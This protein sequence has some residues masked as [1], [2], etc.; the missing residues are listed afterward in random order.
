MTIL[1]L[2]FATL[3]EGDEVSAKLARQ[4]PR[5]IGAEIERATEAYGL[6]AKYLSARG[7]ALDGSPGLVAS[8]TMPS[9]TELLN[10]GEMY[11]AQVVVAGQL[12]LRDRDIHLEA[13]VFQ[14]ARHEVGFAKRYETFPS[15]VF[16]ALEEIKLRIIQLLGL[17]LTDDER[18]ILFRRSTES[19]QALLY[20]LLAED[21]RYGLSIGIVSKDMLAPLALYREALGVDAG[22]DLA[23]IG[24]QQY[25]FGLFEIENVAA[26]ILR[27]AVTLA[28]EYLTE[29]VREALQE[30]LGN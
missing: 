3:T 26:S 23:K 6:K 14:T 20:Y 15:Y 28:D 25:L 16:D 2:P 22:F 5:M 7:S 8:A 18:I 29:D 11:G 1:L 24:L 9:G 10:F 17:T 13:R 12:A 21:E 19:W 27:R 4:I 30:V